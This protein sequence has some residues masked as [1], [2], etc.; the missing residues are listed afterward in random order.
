MLRK[1]ENEM[2]SSKSEGLYVA[3]FIERWLMKKI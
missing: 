1:G 2:F 3:A